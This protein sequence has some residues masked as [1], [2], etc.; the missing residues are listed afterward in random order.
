MLILNEGERLPLQT[1]TIAAISTALSE[2]GIGIIRVS[3]PDAIA[4]TDLIFRA[5][6]G[7]KRLCEAQSH[8]IHYG[9]I[10]DG[11]QELDE[12]LVS[13]MRAPHTYTKE[14][15]TEI[16]CHGGVFLMKKILQVLIGLGIRIA[17][18]GEFTKRAFLNGRID[19]TEAEAVMDLI[20]SKNDFAE[21]SSIQQ[22][23]GNLAAKIKDL[24]SEILYEI[25]F[26]E[27]ALDD[28][29]NYDL[30]G[31]P[32]RLKEKTAQLELELKQLSAHA[33]QG[34]L[35][36]E[37][38]STVIVGKPNAGK[39]SFLNLLTGEEKAIVTEVAGTTRDI[40]E[41][42]VTLG[43]FTLNLIDTAGIRDT[44][45][46]VEKIGVDRA[47]QVAEQADLIFYLVD[48]SVPLDEDD[49]Q[50]I[51]LIRQ[52]PCIIL[53]NKSDLQA[54]ITAREL[55]HWI[56]EGGAESADG[57]IG[58]EKGHYRMV[59]FS[60]KQDTTQ[61]IAGEF[62]RLIRQTAAGTDRSEIPENITESIPESIPEGIQGLVQ[63]ISDILFE[64][65]VQMND[66]LVITNLRHKQSLIAAEHSLFMVDRSIEDG[67]S[68][69]FYSIDLMNA[70]AELGKIIGEEVDDDLVNEIFS[71]FCMGK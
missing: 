70:Y 7:G 49:R 10:T 51:S 53:L 8:T 27:S 64:G 55:Q 57:Q 43:N 25:A 23:K 5:K 20:R 22:L 69:D 33:D 61:N 47:R 24:R 15:I 41:E 3:G 14:D 16:N 66:E 34:K 2:S 37:G 40:I 18:P 1:D 35:L 56:E 13:V 12:V 67:M 30:T 26:I 42:T 21:K 38:I 45:D 32:Q 36:K 6:N 52:K 62:D 48:T 44:Q 50:I 31:Y 9:M 65:H 46:L 63:T 39:S 60:T 71:K 29:E 54:V 28:P 68:E 17:E 4:K 19:L 11:T 58:S 59:R